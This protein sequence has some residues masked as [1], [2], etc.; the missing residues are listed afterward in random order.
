MKSVVIV[1]LGAL[2]S[3]VVLL[4]RNWGVTHWLVDFDKVAPK[5][6]QAQFHTKMGLSKYKTG[7]LQAAM[8]GLFGLVVN[9]RSVKVS[10]LNLRELLLS[11][12]ILDCTDN[13]ET[14]ILI[15]DFSKKEKIP[16][17]HGCLSANGDFARVVWTEHFV[18]DEEGGVKET[19]VDGRNLP[20][21]ALAAALMTNTAQTF[22]EKG[23]KHSFQLS[24]ESLLRIA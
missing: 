1:G 11:D 17:L 14:R 12:L 3:H 15:Q 24:T 6:A 23:V 21:H 4:S 19:C 18:P 16:C 10:K 22:L 7:A 2:G 5:N 8:Q 13:L 20:F 9:T